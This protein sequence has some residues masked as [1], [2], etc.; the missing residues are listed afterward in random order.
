VVKHTDPDTDP[1]STFNFDRGD[2]GMPDRTRR[3]F[4]SHA[5]TQLSR[6]EKPANAI[7]EIERVYRSD[8]STVVACSGGK[9]SMA[10]LALAAESKV[11]HKVLHWDWGARLVPR[12]LEREI[13][14]NIRE[15]VS[16]NRLSV[17]SRQHA[18]LRPFDE[19]KRFRAGLH[20]HDGIMET[21]GSLSRLAGSLARCDR[22][23]RQLVGLRGAESGSRDR[24]LDAT[25][26]FGESLGQP[27][28]FPIRDWSARD[29]WGYIVS[30]GVPCPSYYDRVAHATGNG[31][32]RDYECARLATVHD[33][34]FEQYSADG[35]ASWRDHDIET[36]SNDG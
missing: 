32:P 36:L 14:A 33:P 11:A 6:S 22:V 30:R 9:D 35:L 2:D 19:H 16:D 23:G 1:T 5:E 29:V 24:K 34:E 15:Y 26:L 17:A 12:H 20:E 8:P 4:E 3:T 31:S 21:D 28:A 18:T 7:A 10:V 25:G 13:V 27:A